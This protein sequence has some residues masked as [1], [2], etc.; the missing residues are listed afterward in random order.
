[1]LQLRA[2]AETQHERVSAEANARRARVAAYLQRLH[3]ASTQEQARL[4]GAIHAVLQ[5][6][7]ASTS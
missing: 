4:M 6:Q 5:S 2:F 7:S 3:E 1:M